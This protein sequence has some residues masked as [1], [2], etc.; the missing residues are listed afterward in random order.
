VDLD[1]RQYC[2]IGGRV[3]GGLWRS[4][5]PLPNAANAMTRGGHRRLTACNQ[6]M[7]EPPATERAFQLMARSLESLK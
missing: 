6:R 4:R 5:D 2:G 3:A 7:S 1:L